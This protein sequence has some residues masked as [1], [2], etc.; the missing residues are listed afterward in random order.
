MIAA[1]VQKDYL[2]PLG[3]DLNY[4]TFSGMSSGSIM[5]MQLHIVHSSLIKGVALHAGGPYGQS[6]LD[7]EKTANRAKK[8]AK[9]AS[10]N[11]TIDKLENLKGSPVYISSGKND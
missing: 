7:L 8:L 6:V 1:S 2:P 4:L 5:A 11:G 9:R 3:A 10:K